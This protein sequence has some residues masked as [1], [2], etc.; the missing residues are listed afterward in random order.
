MKTL[1]INV[2]DY[3][4]LSEKAKQHA[5]NLYFEGDFFHP[6]TQNEA[7]T[8]AALFGLDIEKVFYSG[9]HSQGDGA[10]FVGRYAYKKGGLQAVRE[11]APNDKNLHAIVHGLQKAQARNFYKLESETK[12]RGHY[13]HAYCMAVETNHASD[14]YRDI[15][16]AEND[17]RDLMRDFAN[18]IYSQL[19]SEYDYATSEESLSETMAAN[20]WQFNEN[21]KFQA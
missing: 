4:E 13:Y 14:I 10:C 8:I 6:N 17:V 15:G 20:E 21:G 11:Y 18:W 5:R 12:H 7:K 9:F 19:K 3:S 2:F 1:Q 16:S